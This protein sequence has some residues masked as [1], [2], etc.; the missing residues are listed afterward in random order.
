MKILYTTDTFYPNTDGVVRALSLLIDRLEGIGYEV[1]VVGPKTNKPTKNYYGYPGLD[2]PFYKDYKIIIPN[3]FKEFDVDLIHNHGLGL[4][5]IYGLILAKKLRIRAIAHYHTDITYATHYIKAPKALAEIYVRTLLNKHS[6]VLVPSPFMERRLESYGVRNVSVLEIPIDTSRYY[7][8]ERK[9][10]YLLH[11]GRLVKEKK[12]DTIFPYLKSLDIPLYVAG[13][14][15]AYEYYKS[16]AEEIGVEVIF[17]GFVSDE[18]LLELYRDA[19]ALVFASNFDTF[20]LVCV[21]A[22]AS[23]T[24]VIAHVNTAIA[25][26]LNYNLLFQDKD[27]FLRALEY[28]KYIDANQIRAIAKYFDIETVF[29]K[30]LK[31][32]NEKAPGGI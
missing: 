23:G 3:M 7:F 28:T 10:N 27:S 18:K 21:E 4:T 17:L 20:G 2:L 29:P 15:P 11:V 9:E 12:L 14:G 5:S 13:K 26:Y 19:R 24:P 6:Q 32:Y 30:Y 25:D 31:L 16:K 1:I 22:M 8:S